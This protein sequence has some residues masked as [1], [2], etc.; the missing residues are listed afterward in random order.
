MFV[1]YLFVY[2]SL[3]KQTPLSF[4]F[5]V[6]VFVHCVATFI[7]FHLLNVACLDAMQL[8][9]SGGEQSLLNG[10]LLPQS[11]QRIVSSFR[12]YYHLLKY[13]FVYTKFI[14]IRTEL[15]VFASCTRPSIGYYRTWTISFGQSII[16]RCKTILTILYQRYLILMSAPCCILVTDKYTKHRLASYLSWNAFSYSSAVKAC[17]RIRLE[18]KLK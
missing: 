18:L 3:L 1:V 5:I 10:P 16:I 13:K 7:E 8:Y 6:S 15:H 14:C 17:C 12:T 2:E 9:N 11:Y 4:P